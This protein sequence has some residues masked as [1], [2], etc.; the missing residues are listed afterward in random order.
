[1]VRIR[2]VDDADL[3]TFYD[4][5]AD[6]E[7][8]RMAAFAARTRE[9]FVARTA[10]VRP[11]RR[12]QRRLGARPGELRLHPGRARRAGLGAQRRRRAGERVRPRR[13]A[14]GWLPPRPI[15]LAGRGGASDAAPR[16]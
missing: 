11:R 13:L 10:V 8:N 5:Q 9:E 15:P 1:M 7:A 14:I 4:H 2:A 16:G 6:P 12:A 3:A